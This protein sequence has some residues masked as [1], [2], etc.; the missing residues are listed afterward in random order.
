MTAFNSNAV[1]GKNRLP[2]TQF[3]F[4]SWNRHTPDHA[5]QLRERGRERE[6][7][8]NILIQSKAFISVTDQH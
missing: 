4:A 3:Q 6:A 8:S 1:V 5:H 7:D 2:H